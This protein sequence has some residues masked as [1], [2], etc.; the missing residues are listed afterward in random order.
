MLDW[1][2]LLF[3]GYKPRH[4]QKA[5]YAAVAHDKYYAIC[6]HTVR[7]LMKNAIYFDLQW[8]MPRK[9][10]DAMQSLYDIDPD[11]SPFDTYD[12]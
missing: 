6:L 4:I 5:F 1:S 8:R 2:E 9:I 12:L 11:S 10:L 3:L 7:T